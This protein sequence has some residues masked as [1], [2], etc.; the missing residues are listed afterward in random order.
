MYFLNSKYSKVKPID[1]KNSNDIAKLLPIKY[2]I[3]TNNSL[4]KKLD[5]N[6]WYNMKMKKMS[7]EDEKII[8]K[9]INR[10]VLDGKNMQKV[11][12]GNVFQIG[13]IIKSKKKTKFAHK[14]NK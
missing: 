10:D 9:I 2:K 3:G 5:G 1:I 12:L 7:V 8:Y 4:S 13:Q 11:E 6:A 14:K